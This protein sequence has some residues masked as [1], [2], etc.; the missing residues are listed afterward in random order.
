MIVDWFLRWWLRRGRYIWSRFHRR[1]FERKYLSTA[2]PEVHTLEEVAAALQQV[3][4]TPDRPSLIWDCISYPQ[5]TWTTKKDDCDGFSCLA[6]HLLDSLG[7]DYQPVL[8]TVLMHPV[9][10]SHTVCVFRFQDHLR[11]FNNESL[12]QE[13][14]VTYDQIAAQILSGGNKQLIC[15]DVRN[16]F[17]FDLREFHKV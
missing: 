3:Q 7:K 12:R 10:S 14:Y 17:T 8:L 6:A 2:L 13:S 11:F 5:T 4:W 16:P 9:A 15:W 1:F